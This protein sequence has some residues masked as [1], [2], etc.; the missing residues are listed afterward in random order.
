MCL[1][2]NLFDFILIS[3]VLPFCSPRVP[4]LKR[5]GPHNINILNILIGSLLGDGSMEREGNGSRFAFYQEKSHGEYLLWLHRTIS[6]LGYCKQEIPIIKTRKGINGEIRYFYRFRTFTY[7]SF[8]WIYDEFYPKPLGRKVIP[9][10]I[11]QYLSPMALAIWIMDDGTL[12]KNKG[13]KFCTNSFTL[14]EIQYLSFLLKN[15]Y[16]INSSIY[17]I[18]AVNQ[19]NIYI[20]KSSLNILIKIVKPYIHPSMYY[21]L[22]LV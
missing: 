11:D 4:S 10:I 14:K 7:S 5:I 1:K 3:N 20:P 9:K 6:S 17:K 22:N 16:S 2:C 15:K 19:Y 13:L 21:K 8:N 12:Y 18:T